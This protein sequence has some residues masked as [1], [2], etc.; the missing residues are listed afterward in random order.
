MREGI[1]VAGTI[2]VDKI[3]EIAAYPNAGQLTQIKSIGFSVGGL[4]PND[5]IDLKR[6][7]PELPVYAIGKIGADEEGRYVLNALKANGLNVDGVRI[8]DAEKT[9]FTDVMSVVGGQRTFFTYPGASA[10]FGVDDVDFSALNARMFH[11][12]Y[13]LLLEKVDNGDGLK[14]LKKAKE[15]GMLTSIDLVSENSDRYGAV[16]PCLP[17]VD[18]LIVNETEAG[19]L[20]GIEPTKENLPL[21][22]QKLVELGVKE[23][24]II[25]MP[26]TAYCY[27]AGKGTSLASYVLPKG[28]IRGTTGAGDAFCA[29][30]L[31][32]IYEGLSDLEVLERAQMA[33]VGSLCE[34]DATSGVKSVSELK[35]LVKEFS[36]Q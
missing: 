14:L 13:F 1:A 30:A 2:L 11:L 9:S 36:R 33:A 17:Y 22:A 7:C 4:V 8:S 27:H 6:L 35:E 32:A 3:Y 28:F 15:A 34:A 29:G 31:S 24:V 20:S 21:I 16:V 19:A 18:N 23:R 10:A 5:G 12:G 25:H 26:E